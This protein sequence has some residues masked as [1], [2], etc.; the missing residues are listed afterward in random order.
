MTG[1]DR[2]L[3]MKNEKSVR[4]LAWIACAVYSVCL[5]WNIRL[6]VDLLG[7]YLSKEPVS[8]TKSYLDALSGYESYAPDITRV[9]SGSLYTLA[10]LALAVC[11]YAAFSGRAGRAARHVLSAVLA[12]TG[13]I[14]LFDIALSMAGT[15]LLQTIIQLCV[16]A[17][18]VFL[19]YAAHKKKISVI[20]Y[21]GLL[22][23]VLVESVAYSTTI[24][25]SVQD[26]VV[27]VL[28]SVLAANLSGDKA[29]AAPD[30]TEPESQA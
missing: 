21:A 29:A 25:L 23:L 26:A 2:A 6:C 15:G 13:A 22:I 10:F 20:A 16:A 14:V 5:I 3:M 4:L 7:D 18:L 11:I 1:L 27:F 28:L 12:A 19:S 24:S 17:L 30:Q 9:V 8:G